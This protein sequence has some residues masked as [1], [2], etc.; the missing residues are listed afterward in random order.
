MDRAY[1]RVEVNLKKLR[2]NIDA[3]VSRCNAAGIMVA[4]VVKGFNAFLPGVRQF[5]ES[6]CYA[7]ATSRLEHFEEMQQAGVKGPFLAI[8]VPMLGEVPDLV[9]L[10][11]ASLNS[12][13]SVLRAID[14]ECEK[15]GKTHGAVLM[16]DL[17]DLREGFWD[18]D[19][20]V[21]VAAIVE[22]EL[23]NVRL[24]GVGTN[25]GCYGSINPSVENLTEL[26]SITERIEAEIG[27]ELE[28][29]SGGGT[30]T[31]P[32]VLDGTIPKRINHLRIGEA[33]LLGKDLEDLWKVDMHF[34]KKDVFT[35]KA[36]IME[37][38]EKP[39]YPIGEIFV[40]CYGNKVEYED[41]GIRKRALAGLGKLDFVFGD[42]LVPRAPGI[43]V[44]GGSSDHLILDIEDDPVQRQVGDILEFDVRYATMMYTT[45]SRYM[46]MVAV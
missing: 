1:P 16:A 27:R 12:E 8:R 25:L 10:A 28:I 32:L 19:E 44:L 11:D 39:S 35:V 23:K 38:K 20:L 24:L 17:G 9:R 5:E 2:H 43:E 41:R 34:V 30:T 36:E 29:I 6:A 46:K 18:K 22:R 40:D 7:I 42:A 15:Q 21:R 33:I 14:A 4:G 45:A 31:L 13:L 37:I 3:V 26:V